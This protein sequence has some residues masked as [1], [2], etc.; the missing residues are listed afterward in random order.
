MKAVE[1]IEH[2][3]VERSSRRPFF[4]EPAHVNIVVISSIVSQAMNQVR[5]TVIRENY[6]PI[7][8]EEPVELRVGDAVRMHILRLQGHKIDDVDDPNGEI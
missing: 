8:R 7:G 4:I 3:H 5:V 2:Y 1:P 6:R